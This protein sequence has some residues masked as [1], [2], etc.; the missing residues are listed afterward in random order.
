MSSNTIPRLSGVVIENKKAVIKPKTRTVD[1]D[2]ILSGPDLDAYDPATDE[3]DPPYIPQRPDTI[4]LPVP[5]N[6]TIVGTL[7]ADVVKP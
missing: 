5:A 7:G 3:S 2:F 6:V 1:I 4:G